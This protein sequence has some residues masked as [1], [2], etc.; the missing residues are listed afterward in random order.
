MLWQDVDLDQGAVTIGATVNA[1]GQ[2]QPTTKTKAGHRVLS[3]PPAAVEMLSARRAPRPDDVLVFPSTSATPRWVSNVTG[4][5]RGL[6]DD[7]EDEDKPEA[8]A[9]IDLTTITARS[10]RKL[11]STL[12]D[13]AGLTPR[14][15]ADHMGH[16]RPSMSQDVYMIRY[17]LGPTEA[18]GLL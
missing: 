5:L 1:K 11:V 3:L 2:R 12:L 16:A 10:W 13:E 17:G 14:Q 7:L 18:A 9:G 4:Q 8:L 15:I 6:L